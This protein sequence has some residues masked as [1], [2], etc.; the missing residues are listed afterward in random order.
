MMQEASMGVVT[1]EIRARLD[2]PAGAKY[3]VLFD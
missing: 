1:D 2:I 3:V